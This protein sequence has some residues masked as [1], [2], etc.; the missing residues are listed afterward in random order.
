MNLHCCEQFKSFEVDKILSPLY[1]ESHEIATR[2]NDCNPYITFRGII[3]QW[4]IFRRLCKIVMSVSVHPSVCSSARPSVIFPAVLM[5][6]L[7]SYWTDFLEIWYLNIFRKSVEKIQVSLES[8][9]NN[10][11]FIWLHMYIYEN[12][13]LDC[14]CNG[15]YF[16]Q[17][18]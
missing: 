1:R 9:K 16:G 10:G 5:E 11:Y 8:D 12:I 14:F 4:V 15:K 7:C 13:S 17:N 3:L 18:S 6:Q 2:C